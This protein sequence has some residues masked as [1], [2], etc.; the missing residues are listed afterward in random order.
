MEDISMYDAIA[1]QCE[2]NPDKCALYFVGRKITFKMLKKESDA[3]AFFLAKEGIKSKDVITSALPNIPAAVAILYGANKIGAAVNFVH[4]LVPQEKLFSYSEKVGSKILFL[5][6]KIANNF[7]GELV[8]R[9]E[10]TVI[11]GASSSLNPFFGFFYDL[12]TLKS[13]DNLQ[14]KGFIFYKDILKEHGETES[15]GGAD[16]VAAIMHSGGTTG[17]PQSIVLTNQN[18]NCVSENTVRVIDGSKATGGM[19][20]ALPMFHAFGVGV[21][22]HTALSNGYTSYLVPKFSPKKI[23]SM[24]NRLNIE[25]LAGVPAMYEKLLAE[26]K[27]DSK[28]RRK[29]KFAF[30]GGD[31]MSKELKDGFDG[32][33]K[34]RGSDCLLDEGYGL[35][36]MCGVFSV[37]T[38]TFSKEGSLGKPLGDYKAET[39]SEGKKLPRGEYG[40]ICLLGKSMMKGYFGDDISTDRAIFMYDGERYLRTGDLGKVDEEGFI[41]FKQRLKRMVKINGIAVFPSEAESVIDELPFVKESAVVCRKVGEKYKMTAFVCLSGKIEESEAEE[42][43][44]ERCLKKLNKWTNP[45][46]ILFKDYFPKTAFGK[47]DYNELEKSL[48]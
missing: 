30:C 36:E 42:I 18:F 12:A 15:I 5:M 8:G 41:F 34:K 39:F 19:L 17:E 13:R 40:E 31:K 26:K 37:N 4:P 22:I 28:E 33:M 46:E 47:T 10:K 43:I 48:K 16:D 44:K 23:V 38:R 11:C 9:K 14:G 1:K 32:I 21:C 24:M 35:T 7:A 45:K 3:V 29:L 20:A 25:M 27:F 2:K 6:D